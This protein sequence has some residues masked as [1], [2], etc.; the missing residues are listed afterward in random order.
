MVHEN[1]QKKITADFQC[2]VC[3]AIFTSEN[4]RRQHLEKEMHNATEKKDVDTV[5]QQTEIS[6]IHKQ[7][8]ESV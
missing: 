4:D 7:A 6:E 2:F 1:P 5:K 8:Y 3:G